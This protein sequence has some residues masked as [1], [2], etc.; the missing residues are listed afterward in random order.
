MVSPIDFHGYL[1]SE[2]ILLANGYELGMSDELNR[3]YYAQEYPEFAK[4]FSKINKCV[5]SD[6]L[7]RDALCPNKSNCHF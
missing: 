2:P 7:K 4:A 5:V 6:K 3:Y 1:T